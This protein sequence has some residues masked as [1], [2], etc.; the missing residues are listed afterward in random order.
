MRRGLL[1]FSA[2]TLSTGAAVT[3][4]WW[5]VHSVMSGTA[6]DPPRALPITGQDATPELSSTD[7]PEPRKSADPTPR[8]RTGDGGS[9]GV[10]RTPARVPSTAPVTAPPPSPK[11]SSAPSSGTP[12]A[13]EPMGATGSAPGSVK[14]Y[15]TDGGRAVF[16]IGADS[17]ELVS[18]TPA[19]GWSMQVWKQAGLGWIRVDFQSGEKRVSV[20]ATWHEVEPKVSVNTY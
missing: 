15:A 7:R 14:S 16:D 5:G 11:P 12:G 3:L 6:Y 13:D 1:H 8:T 20:I 2:W 10:G 17:V 9:Q 18:A 19:A 4:S